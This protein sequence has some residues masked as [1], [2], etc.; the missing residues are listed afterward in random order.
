MGRGLKLGVGLCSRRVGPSETVGALLPRR[1]PIS[2]NSQMLAAAAATLAP[3]ASACQNGTC[4]GQQP[5]Q[6]LP[7]KPPAG[8]IQI[9]ESFD[10]ECETDPEIRQSDRE[11]GQA[12][13]PGRLHVLR[14]GIDRRMSRGPRGNSR[15]AVMRLVAPAERLATHQWSRLMRPL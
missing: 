5:D 9:M 10:A 3:P 8:A 7:Q 15:T 4:S 13:K 11:H 2:T 6:G 14:V 12:E 1:K